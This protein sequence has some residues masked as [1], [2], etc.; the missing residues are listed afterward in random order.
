MARTPKRSIFSDKA[1]PALNPVEVDRGRRAARA[2][3]NTARGSLWLTKKRLYRRYRDNAGDRFLD[4]P[5]WEAAYL[6][7]Y[8][9]STPGVGNKATDYS[10]YA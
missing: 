5:R 9:S 4:W 2:A 8:G 7:E 6:A 3:V 1:Q 10:G